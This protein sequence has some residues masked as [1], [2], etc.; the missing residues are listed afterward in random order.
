VRPTQNDYLLT[1]TDFVGNEQEFLRRSNNSV[2]DERTLHEIYLEPFR[3]QAQAKPAVFV[4]RSEHVCA[5][6]RL[7]GR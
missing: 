5:V 7:I 6:T 2:I 4:S 3:L 1:C